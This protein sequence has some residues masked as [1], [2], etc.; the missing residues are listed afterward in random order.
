[1]T[2]PANLKANRNEVEQLFFNLIHNALR[3]SKPGVPPRIQ[4]KL[5]KRKDEIVFQVKDNGMG[6]PE[7]ERSTIFKPFH[8]LHN[9]MQSGS[10][11]GLAICQKVV[12]SYGGEIWHEQ[13]P[14][15]GSVFCFTMPKA[16]PK[17]Q[18]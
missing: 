1:L 13:V 3:Y 5:E 2:T 18:F 14:E 7:K 16:Q 10:G 11:L 17:G 12:Q 4:I 6:I 8:R 15:G 9:R